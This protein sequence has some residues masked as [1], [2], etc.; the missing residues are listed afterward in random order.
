MQLA[1]FRKM[2]LYQETKSNRLSFRVVLINTL[3]GLFLGILICNIQACNNHEE[4][5]DRVVITGII[6]DTLIRN[7][8][9][10]SAIGFYAEPMARE[11]IRNDSLHLALKITQPAILEFYSSNKPEFRSSIYVSPGDSV[12]LV[13][14]N[15][16]PRFEGKNSAHYNYSLDLDTI[17]YPN[18]RGDSQKYFDSCEQTY[19][20]R[21]EQFMLYS[22]SHRGLSK[23]FVKRISDELKFEYLSKLILPVRWSTDL[24]IG[25]LREFLGPISLNQFRRGDLLNSFHFKNA[26]SLYMRF[27]F[28]DSDRHYSKD[29]LIHEKVIISENFDGDL[30][31]YLQ[32]RLLYDYA[33]NLTPETIEPIQ[34]FANILAKDSISNYS[35]II[36]ELEHGL[37]RLNQIL[38]DSINNVSLIDI[39]NE[40]ESLGFD[41]LL[42]EKKG[43]IKV[44]DFWASWC[45]PCIEEIKQGQ[46]FKQRISQEHNIEWIYLSIDT[47]IEKWKQKSKELEEFGLLNNNFMVNENDLGT[48]SNFFNLEW[49]PKYSLFDG[50]NVLILN[51]MP[52]PSKTIQFEE[53]LKQARE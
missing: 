53:I 4:H 51:D 14:L 49:I 28:I 6:R 33:S 43:R 25:K 50:R 34:D 40:D 10:N 29:H 2:E 46:D 38:P 21:K 31:E 1:S 41:F 37:K 5:S 18:F 16:K 32:V 17:L 23:A 11:T 15:G 30:Q 20:R 22:E 52:R 13:Q 42:E 12:H 19:L 26:V 24:N 9:V 48:L 39:V 47:D 44:I 8:T 27:V 35:E 45:S 7:I 36:K 3:K